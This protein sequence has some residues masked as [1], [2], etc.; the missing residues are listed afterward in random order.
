MSESSWT[1]GSGVSVKN[2]IVDDRLSIGASDSLIELLALGKGSV[3]D[4]LLQVPV[5]SSPGTTV[6]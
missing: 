4:G 6:G 5:S 2:F 3:N 1:L